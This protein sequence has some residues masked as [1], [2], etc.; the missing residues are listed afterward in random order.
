[1]GLGLLALV[2]VS[3]A[4][5]ATEVGPAQIKRIRTGWNG[6][7]FAIETDLPVSN[8]ARCPTPDAYMSEGAAPGYKTH[9]AAALPAFATG[10]KIRIII[11]DSEC[12]AQRPKIWGIYIEQ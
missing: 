5:A 8:P 11:S 3:S 6:E 10:K 4:E 9:Y 7:A 2:S 12:T 1:L